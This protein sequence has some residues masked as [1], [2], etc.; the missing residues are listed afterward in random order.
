MDLKIQGL[1]MIDGDSTGLYMIL[2]LNILLIF[3]GTSSSTSKKSQQK[4]KT[5]ISKDR[6]DGNRNQN[7]I[8]KQRNRSAKKKQV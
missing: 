1:L 4:K 6:A 3:S 5:I 7:R 8:Q 2:S